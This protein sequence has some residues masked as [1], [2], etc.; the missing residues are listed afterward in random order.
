MKLYDINLAEV[1][2]ALRDAGER[3]DVREIADAMDKLIRMA[4]RYPKDFRDVRAHFR[5]HRDMGNRNESYFKLV[6]FLEK[7]ELNYGYRSIVFQTLLEAVSVVELTRDKVNEKYLKD[8]NPPAFDGSRRSSLSREMDELGE[9]P[10]PEEMELAERGRLIRGDVFA[11]MDN[12][13]DSV[14]RYL[15]EKLPIPKDTRSKP[16][17]MRYSVLRN[18]SVCGITIGVDKI[19]DIEGQCYIVDSDKESTFPLLKKYFGIK[20]YS[21]ADNHVYLEMD[22]CWE[23]CAGFHMVVPD[24]DGKVREV[25]YMLPQYQI[26]GKGI[27]DRWDSIMRECPGIYTYKQRQWVEMIIS[28]DWNKT[29]KILTIDMEKFSDTIKRK[30]LMDLLSHLGIPAPVIQELSELYDLSIWDVLTNKSLGHHEVVLQGQYSVFMT[31]SIL[32][33]V[34]QR[35]ILSKY[36]P[37]VLYAGG[38]SSSRWFMAVLGDDTG[39]VFRQGN[40]L[41]IQRFVEEVYGSFGM[42][43]NELKSDHLD[44]G[45]GQADFAK[46]HFDRYGIIDKLNPK[47]IFNNNLDGVIKDILGLTWSYE[48]KLTVLTSLFGE[49][50]ANG[51]MGLH[52][53]NG[54]L[55]DRPITRED[56]NFFINNLDRVNRLINDDDFPSEYHHLK[57][58][59]SKFREIDSWLH[60]S[61]LEL[62]VDRKAFPE[63]DSMP[64]DEAK[65]EIV[66]VSVL[67]A[68]KVGSDFDRQLAYESVGLT[69]EDLEQGKEEAIRTRTPNRRSILLDNFAKYNSFIAKR[70]MGKKGRFSSMYAPFVLGYAD[71]MYSSPGDLESI[72][73]ITSIK[74]LEEYKEVE[75]KVK[76]SEL[77][78]SLAHIGIYIN[79]RMYGQNW[80]CWISRWEN[81]EAISTKRIHYVYS[82]YY[83]AT[84]DSI[85]NDWYQENIVSRWIGHPIDLTVDEFRRLLIGIGVRGDE[86]IIKRRIKVR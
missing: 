63:F 75:V 37:E 39:M 5:H 85:N 58:L 41:K 71:R 21:S 42:R 74:N 79:E 31:M 16:D 8:P 3:I 23:G 38:L 12:T 11:W 22:N 83:Y 45:A 26:L 17:Y 72:K 4:R 43:I 50:G 61:I 10:D 55:H 76:V 9:N 20:N 48:K 7:L 2:M 34:L 27:A 84:V 65:D 57:T 67:N 78:R 64:D 32:N 24:K 36:E 29:L 53:I 19:S 18:G 66:I 15:K 59:Q 33:L 47:N 1:L 6:S 60:E 46:I 49:S 62:F 81:G 69:Q 77:R 30:F 14:I 25:Y 82:D 70:R 40:L 56:V 51:I 28:N 80:C 52:P 44:S 68:D 13:D 73:Q 86:A 35:Y 54:G